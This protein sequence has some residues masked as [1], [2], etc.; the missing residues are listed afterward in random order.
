M[1]SKPHASKPT[2]GSAATEQDRT[3]SAWLVREDATVVD[4]LHLDVYNLAQILGREPMSVLRHLRE[5]R[6]FSALERIGMAFEFEP[7]SE[8]EVE[9]FGLALAGVPLASTLAWCLARADRPHHDELLSMMS[10]EDFRPGM[11]MAR[12]QGIWFAS[13]NDVESMRFIGDMPAEIVQEAVADLLDKMEAPTARCVMD[14][15]E[16]VEPA[17]PQPSKWTGA[18]PGANATYSRKSRRTSSKAR[19]AK[20]RKW[21]PRKKYWAMRRAAA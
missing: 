6:I 10:Q 21:I 14:R 19:P 18:S 11:E 17:Q 20:S 16:G 5:D 7:G 13:I 8:E 12:T 15:L 3:L 1:P 9:L 4:N 2:P